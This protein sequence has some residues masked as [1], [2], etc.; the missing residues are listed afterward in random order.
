MPAKHIDDATWRLIEKETLKVVL[1]TEK[2][3]KETEILKALLLKGL[4]TIDVYEYEEILKK[5]KK[6]K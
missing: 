6:G 3:F 2:I 4:N 5:A 1:K